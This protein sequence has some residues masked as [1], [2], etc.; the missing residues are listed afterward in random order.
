[1]KSNTTPEE[2]GTGSAYRC[3]GIGTVEEE[4]EKRKGFMPEEGA[5]GLGGK[6]GDQRLDSMSGT[7]RASE[8]YSG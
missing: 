7:E 6:S 2:R 5:N 1:M 4:K 8:D 3:R